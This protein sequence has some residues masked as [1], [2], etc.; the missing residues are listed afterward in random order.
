MAEY[1]LLAQYS[2]S[3]SPSSASSAM[4]YVINLDSSLCWPGWGAKLATPAQ[5]PHQQTSFSSSC[6]SSHKGKTRGRRWWSCSR[7]AYSSNASR[8]AIPRGWQKGGGNRNR[9]WWLLTHLSS[10]T[11]CAYRR[12]AKGHRLVTKGRR[13]AERFGCG[14]A[15]CRWGSYGLGVRR[16][17][18]SLAGLWQSERRL[19]ALL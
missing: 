8:S 12:S 19:T 3:Q 5:T 18:V 11:Q 16:Y 17:S 9:D 15:V 13:H 1:S 7:L 2:T 4:P 6:D 14:G 10:I